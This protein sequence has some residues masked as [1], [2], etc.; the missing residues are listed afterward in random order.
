[1]SSSELDEI[2]LHTALG[3]RIRVKGIPPRTFSIS[4]PNLFPEMEKGIY[5]VKVFT[6]S[7]SQAIFRWVLE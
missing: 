7:G 2:S 6:R 4:L 1:M 3:S 5:F